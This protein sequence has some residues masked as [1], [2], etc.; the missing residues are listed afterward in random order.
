MSC[1][2]VFKKVEYQVT[3]NRVITYGHIKEFLVNYYEYK[4]WEEL[5]MDMK[6]AIMT[7]QQDGPY[8]D[9][10]KTESDALCGRLNCDLYGDC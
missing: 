8:P 1:S 6:P 9:L 4:N 10:N 7:K 5:H 3:L 2:D